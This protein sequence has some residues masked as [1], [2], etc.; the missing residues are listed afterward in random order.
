MSL[1]IIKQYNLYIDIHTLYKTIYDN[2]VY[3]YI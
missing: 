1:D 2:N 3:S